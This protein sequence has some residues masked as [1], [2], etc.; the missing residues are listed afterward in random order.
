M[1]TA[2][3]YSIVIVGAGPTGLALGNLLGMYGIDALILERSPGLSDCAKAIAI[4]DEGLR[5]C[6]S[7]GL[8]RI[9]TEHLLFDVEARYLS[10]H[11][12]LARVAPTRKMNGFP[13]VSTFHQ[14]D[15]ET[16]LFNGLRRFDCISVQ[17]S[18]T[19]E[20]FE[21]NE[22]RVLLTV[23][24]HEGGRRQIECRYLLACDGG[25]SSIRHA[26]NI[27][28]RGS[29]YAQKWL[30]VDSIQDSQP[31]QTITFF[32]NPTRP[33]VTVPS[34]QERRRW[35][36]M[37]FPG[38]QEADLL[39]IER[40]HTMIHEV[41]GPIQPTIERKVVYTFH[42]MLA[43]TFSRGRV[44][45]LGDAAHL[46][47]PFGGQG[48]NCGLRDAHNLAWK[49]AL[50]LHELAAPALLDTYTIERR[51]HTAQMIRFSTFLG[52]I[53]M[54]PSRPLAFLRDTI[55]RLLNALS[56][57]RSYLSEA[58]IKPQPRYRKG[59]L[60]PARSAHSLVG[61]MLPQ[62]EII[63]SGERRVLLDN[64]LGSNFALLRLHD[65]PR[66]AF[67]SLQSNLWQRLNTRFLSIQPGMND[68]PLKSFDQF[69]L[70][71][72]DRYI[73]GAFDELEEEMF[74]RRLQKSL[75]HE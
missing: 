65:D 72:P 13:F 61:M 14:P 50:V 44:F 51:A 32:C 41:S 52:S 73:Y 37:L 19:L 49:L 3:Y 21:Q 28:M 22:E 15:L 39:Q 55:F 20:T 34:P 70:V 57:V 67:A 30:V 68:F 18:H 47:P 8:H 36:F 6:Q 38:E 42:A 24:A 54:T 35:E 29:T 17:F 75:C 45:L 26:L 71:R 60:Q 58:G 59:F 16:I 27:P 7:M 40:I 74:I 48:M 66:Q 2:S 33:A 53:I 31:S 25:K 69:V 62:P 4:D 46:M 64:A 12:P 10:G 5:I 1:S 56:P 9:I 43:D 23:Q 63:R 11:Y